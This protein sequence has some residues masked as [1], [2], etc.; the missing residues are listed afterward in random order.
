MLKNVKNPFKYNK[1]WTSGMTKISIIFSLFFVLGAMQQIHGAALPLAQLKQQAA[2]RAPFQPAQQASAATLAARVF[3]VPRKPSLRAAQPP[4]QVMPA[5]DLLPSC[6]IQKDGAQQGQRIY[7]IASRKRRTQEP[8]NADGARKLKVEQDVA[9][10]A[11]PPLM[12]L[13]RRHSDPAIVSRDENKKEEKKDDAVDDLAALLVRT[14][15]SQ[16]AYQKS[17]ELSYTAQDFINKGFSERHA[18]NLAKITQL[19]NAESIGAHAHEKC[20]AFLIGMSKSKKVAYQKRNTLIELLMRRL[21][22]VPVR[23]DKPAATRVVSTER[24]AS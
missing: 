15:I 17:C 2:A 16:A 23:A 3:V 5:E 24:G 12:Q 7:H 19:T 13:A 11:A 21:Q 8:D 6:A 4:H 9:K 20:L 18:Q 10:P 1:K 22:A 14:K